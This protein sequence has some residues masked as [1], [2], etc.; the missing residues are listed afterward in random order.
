M[1]AV[2]ALVMFERYSEPASSRDTAGTGELWV[3]EATTF[4]NGCAAPLDAL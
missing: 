3:H 2:A 4:N 1:V